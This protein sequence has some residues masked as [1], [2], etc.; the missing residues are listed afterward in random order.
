MRSAH[1]TVAVAVLLTAGLLS[2]PASAA[3]TAS[4]LV[5][6]G[7][8]TTAGG[9]A[10][11]GATVDLYAWP[12]DPVL[13]RLKT[14]QAV[15]EKLI[16][17]TKAGSAGAFSVTVPMADLAAEQD[18]GGYTNLEAESDGAVWFFTVKA[19]APKT[20]HFRLDAVEPQV[21]GGYD[22][23][24]NMGH[25]WTT[26]GMGVIR[27]GGD[28]KGDSI[29][30]TY[31]KTQSSTLGIE[32]SASGDQGSFTADG[33]DSSSSTSTLSYP[34]LTKPG[35]DTYQTQFSVGYFRQTCIPGTGGHSPVQGAAKKKAKCLQKGWCYCPKAERG[36]SHCAFQIHTTGW[37]LAQNIL[38][39][40]A[41]P[42][43]Y[44]GYCGK[45]LA[46]GSAQTNTEAARTYSL[47]F[48]IPYTGLGASAQT[49]YDTDLQLTYSFGSNGYVCSTTRQA[50][51][52]SPL[53]EVVS[54]G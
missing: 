19:A 48:S 45:V 40:V 17:T 34:A 3:A 37:W 8:V 33:T 24:H 52:K 15:P 28:T 16:G 47:G 32:E 42:K 25:R 2:L 29:S 5:A 39:N 49:G 20:A 14:G 10:M 12:P 9:K 50:P 26:I 7:T 13:H 43:I 44:Y 53:M 30:F 11:P 46:G 31:A 51:G 54:G 35:T 38:H 41:P 18:T 21:C 4:A 1:V 27:K 6:T 22:Y 23:I 36:K